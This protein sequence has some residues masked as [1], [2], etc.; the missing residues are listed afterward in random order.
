MVR[1]WQKL[2]RPIVPSSI[3]QE[4][5]T[6]VFLRSDDPEIKSFLGMPNAEALE[7]FTELRRRKNIFG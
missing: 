7:V 3:G 1:D 4:R 6:N 2:S 5:V